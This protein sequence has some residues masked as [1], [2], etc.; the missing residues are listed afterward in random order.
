ME[1]LI[2]ESCRALLDRDVLLKYAPWVKLKRHDELYNYVT[3]EQCIILSS[4]AQRIRTF[5]SQ[6]PF[7][8]DATFMDWNIAA[9]GARIYAPQSESE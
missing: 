3:P 8:L 4:S 1:R 6:N 7:R 9:L 5:I 2:S